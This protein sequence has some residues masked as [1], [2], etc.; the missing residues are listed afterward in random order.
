MSQSCVSCS[1]DNRS[2]ASFCKVCG[3]AFKAV[4]ASCGDFVGIEEVH[5]RGIGRIVE[6]FTAACGFARNRRSICDCSIR[7]SIHFRQF[8]S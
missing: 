5:G 1:T 8:A 3:T 4:I 6:Y 2:I 7:F